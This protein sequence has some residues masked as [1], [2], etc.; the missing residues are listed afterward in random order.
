M[1][2][3][4]EKTCCFTCV[5]TVKAPSSALSVTDRRLIV[6]N[7][8]KQCIK[9]ADHS[10]NVV[11]AAN[12]SAVTK[13]SKDHAAVSRLTE[14]TST[15]TREPQNGG[16]ERRNRPIIENTN[17][18]GALARISNHS[19]GEAVAWHN[20][21]NHRLPTQIW[22]CKKKIPPPA[23][24]KTRSMAIAMEVHIGQRLRA[25]TPSRRRPASALRRV[26]SI[27]ERPARWEPVSH[28]SLEKK[29]WRRHGVDHVGR[30]SRQCGRTARATPTRSSQRTAQSIRT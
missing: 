17:P 23:K 4:R 21:G 24:T 7:R 16:R 14:K 2:R 8:D 9:L 6:T 28:R 25:I 13:A 1:S 19:T 29:G 12:N 11:P 18:A 30:A 27:Q 10:Q 3:W 22:L 5:R 26:I 15:G 20:E